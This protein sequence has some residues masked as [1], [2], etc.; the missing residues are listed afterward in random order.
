[1]NYN[2][3]IEDTSDPR[4]KGYYKE[5]RDKI[6]KEMLN[7]YKEETPYFSID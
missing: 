1:M 3:S 2:I 4:R 5:K 6:L 7:N